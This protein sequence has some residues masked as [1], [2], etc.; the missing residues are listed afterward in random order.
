MPLNGEEIAKA[1]IRE[2][3]EKGSSTLDLRKLGLTEIPRSL[4]ELKDQLVELLVGTYF[5]KPD[6]PS[7]QLPQNQIGDIS[8]L[9][10]FSRLQRLYLTGSQ[11]LSLEP[12]ALLS[13]LE[14]LD[15]ARTGLYD[16]DG[17]ENLTRLKEL[18]L[19]ECKLT[20]IERLAGLAELRSLEVGANNL[21]RLDLFQP[22]RFDKLTELGLS[23]NPG[24]AEHIGKLANLTG[25][26]ELRVDFLDLYN[27]QRVPASFD[28]ES[29]SL[30]H[31]QIRD[32]SSIDRF[33][34]LQFL[35]LSE[36]EIVSGQG[37][38]QLRELKDL[39]LG[40]NRIKDIGFLADLRSL[41]RL[42][43][44]AN[45]ID[46]LAP[47][48]QLTRLDELVV[49]NNQI[50]DLRPLAGLEHLSYMWLYDN[51]IKDLR[52]IVELPSL[53]YANLG[54]NKITDL[55]PL[56]ALAQRRTVYLYTEREEEEGS[57]SGLAIVLADN[58]ITDPPKQYLNAG[59]EAVLAYWEQQDKLA[60]SKRQTHIINEAK[61]IIV[62]NSHVGKSTLVHLLRRRKLPPRALPSTHGL[63]FS[64]WKPGWVIK[65]AEL[66]VN[67]ID[68]GGQEY[69]HGTHHL[70]FHDRALFL[71]LW[72]PGSNDNIKKETPVG[73]RTRSETIQH[74]SIE[75]WLNAIKIYAG[76]R[77]LPNN[78]ILLPKRDGSDE[79]YV[80]DLGN[81]EGFDLGSP[82][83][84]QASHFKPASSNRT[85]LVQTFM[86]RYG[87]RFLNLEKLQRRYG[88]I[89]DALSVSMNVA[90]GT[91]K[92]IEILRLK[93]KELYESMPDS[94]SQSYDEQWLA[95]RDYIT[96]Y[97]KENYRI[98]AISA[99]REYFLKCTGQTADTDHSDGEMR[100]MCITLNYWGVVLYRYEIEELR[101]IVIINPQYFTS[102][103]HVLLTE[104]LKERN[105]GI[106]GKDVAQILNIGPQETDAF[107]KVL[108]VFKIL[109]ELPH[110]GADGEAAYISPMYLGER[111]AYISLFLSQFVTYYKIS[112][113]GYFHKGILLDCFKELGEELLSEQGL[114]F[115]WQWGLVLKR[116]ERVVCIEFDDEHF[117]QVLIRTIRKGKEQL[118]R[119]TFLM[120]IFKAFERINR[121]Y[122][123]NIELSCDGIDFV[124]KKVLKERMAAGLNKFDYSGI[125]FDARDLSFLLAPEDMS[126]ALKRIFVS[127]SSRNRKYLDSLLEH[128]QAYKNAGMVTYWSDLFLTERT[129]W[130]EQIK[131]EMENANILIMLLS[132]EYLAT[133]YIMKEEVTLALNY[134]K[135]PS[136]KKQVFWVLLRPCRYE[137]F[138]EI[139]HYPIYPLKE[140][141]GAE[142]RAVQKAISEYGNQDRQWVKLLRKIVE[143]T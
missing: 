123:V 37:L 28:L 36:N 131:A 127:Y 65:G 104:K 87:R 41:T 74:F 50:V 4:L 17:I 96:E 57:G 130:D 45:E 91:A 51:A 139:A 16:L 85:L 89:A 13:E 15:L 48:R 93:I 117:N 23:G 9:G 143:E 121:P 26:K 113:D 118:G 32:V 142:E 5:K 66:T 52:P 128:L 115:S 135:A 86:D 72:E 60:V 97:E 54:K 138:P 82:F 62:G 3:K 44:Y 101:D 73:D 11:L 6:P 90:D 140:M 19:R 69:Y 61:L 133:D 14:V 53:S 124:S 2:A 83:F 58:P 95:I 49:G 30:A 141:D 98:L 122:E 39:L 88:T 77:P 12:L 114:Y 119:D 99:F 137:V 7:T 35:D 67:I 102:R 34:S 100:I 110:N 108:K 136:T 105:N 112:Y 70:F 64:T 134:A 75:Y 56:R 116:G 43:M 94:S 81:M 126:S 109:F 92:G 71:L 129:G 22:G 27:L 8:I 1:R 18:N 24:V 20:S 79:Y 21:S 40:V 120:D 106:T 111:P 42:S 10:Q 76:T 55:K 68:F 33:G 125:P 103:I 107:I 84:L 78:M 25:L 38:G 80:G 31:N 29:L 47:V 46:N 59:M 63:K 132:P